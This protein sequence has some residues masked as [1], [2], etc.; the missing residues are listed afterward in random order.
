[1]IYVSDAKKATDKLN[2]LVEVKNISAGEQATFKTSLEKTV[3]YTIEDIFVKD[4]VSWIPAVNTSN[5]KILDGAYFQMASVG[6]SQL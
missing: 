2:E 6:S 3:L 1:M 4:T 5:G